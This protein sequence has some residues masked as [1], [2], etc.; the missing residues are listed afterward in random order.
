MPVVR[1][2]SDQEISWDMF[3]DGFN[4]LLWNFLLHLKGS[5]EK[6]R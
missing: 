5:A 1:N 2:E 6:G 4:F 3:K